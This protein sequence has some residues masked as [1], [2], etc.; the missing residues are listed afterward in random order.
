MIDSQRLRPGPG[1]VLLLA[2]ALAPNARA[3]M[4]DVD[5]LLVEASAVPQPGTVRVFANGGGQTAAADTEGTANVA[6]SVMWVPLRGLAGDVGAYYQTGSSGPSV[7]LRY[8]L[9]D[10]DRAGVNLSLGARYKSVGFAGEGSG[11]VEALLAL[12]RSWGR[13]DTALNLVWGWELNDPGMDA[14]IKLLVGWR[15]TDNL[16]AGVEARAQCEV[17]DEDGWKGPQM[18]QTDLRGGATAFWRIARPVTVQLLL[19]A[20]KPVGVHGAGFLALGAFSFD[21]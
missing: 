21:L 2:L 12:G 10:Q 9:L 14:E 8:Q 19:G 3:Q 7:R 1:L 5:G 18:L 11:E 15:F 13:L 16:R 6:G 20:G 4:L 17:H